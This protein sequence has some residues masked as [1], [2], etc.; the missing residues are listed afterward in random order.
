MR[1]G[2]EVTPVQYEDATGEEFVGDF[3][4][5]YHGAHGVE[6]DTAAFANYN[7]ENPDLWEDSDLD[8]EYTAA[9]FELHPQLHDAIDWASTNLP[10]ETLMLTTTLLI[11]ATMPGSTNPLRT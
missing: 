7:Y 8:S 11:A 9:L 5:D 4:V 1:H 3:A 10:E 6:I 2:M